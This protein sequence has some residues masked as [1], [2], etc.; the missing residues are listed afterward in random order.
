MVDAKFI[1]PIVELVA[2]SERFC[3]IGAALRQ[4]VFITCDM[5]WLV[6]VGVKAGIFNRLVANG[7]AKMFWMPVAT[8]RLQIAATNR[9]LTRFADKS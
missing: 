9:F 4:R 6:L 1:A 5:A 3:A 2:A 7:A 8:Q